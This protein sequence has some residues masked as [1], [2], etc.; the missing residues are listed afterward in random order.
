MKKNFSEIDII[1]HDRMFYLT[2]EMLNKLDRNTMLNS[3]E[4]RSPFTSPYIKD[5]IMKYRFNELLKGNKLKFILKNNYYKELGSKII[6]RKKHGFN[7]P[8]DFLLKNQWKKI[9]YKT[10]S[11]N[12]FLV[13]NKIIKKDSILKINEML[14]DKDKNHGHT[15]LA[16]IGISFWLENNQW[17][18]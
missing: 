17:K 2:N 13:K 5:V 11:N 10:F 3:I 15:I 9:V 18:L 6:N 7:F 12:S 4:G 16:F 1:N 14:D 8:I